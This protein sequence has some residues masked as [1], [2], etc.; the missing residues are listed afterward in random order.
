[1][2]LENKNFGDDMKHQVHT[3]LIVGKWEEIL[4]SNFGMDFGISLGSDVTNFSLKRTYS[5]LENSKFP[6]FVLTFLS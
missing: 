1:M 2:L 5:S 6:A 3:S 4:L